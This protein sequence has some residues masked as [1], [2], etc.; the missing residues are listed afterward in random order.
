MGC[1]VRYAKDGLE[2]VC[3]DALDDEG[4]VITLTGA[5]VAGGCQKADGA[6]DPPV[7]LNLMST[8][9]PVTGDAEADKKITIVTEGLAWAKLSPNANRSATI[10]VGEWV[11]S[12]SDGM[13]IE[14]EAVFSNIANIDKALGQAMQ[15]VAATVDLPTAGRGPFRSGYILVWLKPRGA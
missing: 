9:N 6:G 5:A 3:E 2:M 1:R 4:Y 10:S 12:H 11:Q 15:E 7:G 8:K 13:V 14:L